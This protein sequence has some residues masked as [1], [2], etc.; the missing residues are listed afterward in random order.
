MNS[1]S[2]PKG[3][4]NVAASPHWRGGGSL[5]GMQWVWILALMPA[6][7]AAAVVFGWPGLR[8]IALSVFTC[9]VADLAGARLLP[10]P[11]RVANGNGAVLGLLL[12]M[13][14]PVNAPWWLVVVGAVL[15]VVVGK[16]LF[17]GWGAHPVHPV[18]LGYAML[19]VSWPAR[20]DHTASLLWLDWD[21]TL[22]EPMRLVKTL[23]V[24]AEAS[25][26]RMDLL[27]GHQVA[28]AGGGM[29]IWL[30]IG[31]LIMVLV[32]E[33]PWQV[34]LGFLAGVLGCAWLLQWTAPGLTAT[35]VF[36][37]LAGNTVLAAFFL[38]PEH[39]NSP[40]NPWPM[41]LYGLLGGILL[42][43]VR[44]FS[45]HI[46]GAI[47]AVLLIN[48]CAPLLDRLAPRVIGLNEE[49]SDA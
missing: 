26:D 25:F 1:V 45:I 32:R 23:G 2:P 9:V 14:L 40:V 19:T 18:A 41:L 8:V 30:A 37:L 31:G 5:T 38:A 7:V 27:L 22:V 6:V 39:T 48:L 34:P 4:L 16:R 20:L 29:V 47:F 10:S 11:D 49:D 36:Q 3:L 42:V 43:L 15:T 35:P 24:G 13:L 33:I 44:A 12:A 21:S 17:G 46:D 28:G